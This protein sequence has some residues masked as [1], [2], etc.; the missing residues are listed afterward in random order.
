MR[1][2]IDCMPCFVRQSLEAV[3]Y[4]TPET[5]IHEQVVRA[6][7]N[8][9][10][11]MDMNQSPPYM[12]QQIHRWIRNLSAVE[13]PYCRV[14]QQFNSAAVSLYPALREKIANSEN[15]L[16]TA[17]RLAIAGNIIDFG[18]FGSLQESELAITIENCLTAEFDT[19]ELP[20]FIHAVRDAEKILYLAD[21]AGEIGFDRLLI[22][23]LPVEK[24]TVVVKSAPIINDATMEDAQAVGLTS[25]VEVIENGSDAPGTLLND[26]S[27]DFQSRF[28]NADLVIAKGQ[29]NYETL[30]D[31]DQSIYFLLKIK[32]SVIANHM[33]CDVGRMIFQHSAAYKGKKQNAKT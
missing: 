7:L 11:E 19:A 18:I 1:T 5:S 10:S 17:I 8:L 32:C 28:I 12:A 13:D 16:E 2:Y 31:I 6:V 24:V 21:N 20:A 30:S 3:R 33:G 23:H 15:Q 4:A 29:G 22:E 25:I 14:K 27:A 26:C 9:A